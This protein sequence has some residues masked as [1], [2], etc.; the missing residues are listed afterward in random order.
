MNGQSPRELDVAIIGGGAAGLAT[1]IFSAQAAS[2]LRIAIFDGAAKLGAKILVSG[3]GRCN[4]T[5]KI[6]VAADYWG[7]S[8]NVIRRVLSF[9]PVAETVRFFQEIGV[10]LHEEEHGKL[11]PNSNKA[12]TVVDALIRAATQLNVQIRCGRRVTAIMWESERSESGQA[13]RAGAFHLQ[14][15]NET[16]SAHVA[17]LATGGL[18]LPKTGSD[19]GGYLLAKSLGHSISPT[20]AGLAPL[21]LDGAFHTALSGI[22]CDTE[23]TITI[24]GEKP[25]SIRGMML[26]THFGISG[27]VVL[28][29][30]RH[31]SRARLQ[32][33]HVVIHANFFP[34]LDGASLERRWIEFAAKN[35]R[36]RM[37]ALLGETLPARLSEALLTSCGVAPN[38]QIG[39]L[40][41][42]RR[43]RLARQLTQWGLPIRDSRGYA[44]AEV[45]A[46]GVPLSEIDPGTLQSR[47]RP[48]LFF[49]GEILDVDG[50]LGGFNF[51]WAWSSAFTAARGITRF[52]SQ[53][54]GLGE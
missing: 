9:L 20:C 33:K 17:V 22:A 4:V 52:F 49:V 50:R 3:G 47:I 45:T 10:E 16:I 36:R 7:G 34:P 32:G 18:S 38:T 25:L 23:L 30:S 6:V 2:N 8:S 26:W 37:D 51:Q 14:I 54:S 29:I 27:P 5:N 42:D 43:R 53:K 44:Y 40:A 31:W 12:R 39:N 11:F 15:A 48:G 35:P 46:G 1:A 28:N 19:G 21:L 41:R 13:E 24:T